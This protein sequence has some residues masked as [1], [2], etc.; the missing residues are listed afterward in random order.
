V[1]T[2]GRFLQ[3]GDLCRRPHWLDH[4]RPALRLDIDA[5]DQKS[6]WRQRTRDA[7]PSDDPICAD[8][9]HWNGHHG[10][11]LSRVLVLED[12]RYHRLYLPRYPGCSPSCDRFNVRCGF[13]QAR[14]RIYLCVNYNQQE[15]L[16]LRIQQVH[17][18]MDHQ[19]WVYRPDHDEYD[20]GGGVVF[21]WDIVLVQRQGI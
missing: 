4:G 17:Y 5:L 19:G 20:P 3:L 7:S 8:L 9:D 2:P 18:S 10:G 21:V 16:G 14:C 13:L 15:C 12:H 1:L 6:R 11:G